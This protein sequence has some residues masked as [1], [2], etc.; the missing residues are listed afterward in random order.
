MEGIEPSAAALT[1][2]GGKAIPI[3]E[4]DAR[5]QG[6]PGSYVL[7]IRLDEWLP[8][9]F[10]GCETDL[11]AGWYA[12]AGSAR[13]PGGVGARIARHLSASKKV[14]WHVDALTLAARRIEALALP[15]ASECEIAARL[16]ASGGFGHILPGFGSSDCRTCASHLLAWKG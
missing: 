4:S 11:T 8:V 2:L 15:D 13:G 5:G 7:L 6:W 14:H 16:C 1:V 10:A 3:K 12:Y 9:R